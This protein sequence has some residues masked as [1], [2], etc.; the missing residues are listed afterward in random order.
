MVVQAKHNLRA[1]GCPTRFGVCDAQALPFVENSFDGVVANHMLY[2]VPDLG[3]ALSEFRRVLRPDGRLFAATNG[4]Q[5]MHQYRQ[6]AQR[7]AT[8]EGGDDTV[9]PQ[10]HFAFESGAE[11]LRTSFQEVKLH[12]YENALAVTEVEPLVAYALSMD[13]IRWNKAREAA[14]RAAVAQEIAAKGK[15]EI[16]TEAGLFEATGVR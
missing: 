2:H 6:L 13:V 10:S 16:T 7:I 3:L 11:V 4:A 9:W 15:F 8:E 12:R 5:H 1:V 14:F